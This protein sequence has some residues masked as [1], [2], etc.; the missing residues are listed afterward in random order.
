MPLNYSFMISFQFDKNGRNG[1]TVDV[2]MH[3]FGNSVAPF[4]LP[5]FAKLIYI[6]IDMRYIR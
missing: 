6:Y 2:G 1:A 5:R 3:C 4:M